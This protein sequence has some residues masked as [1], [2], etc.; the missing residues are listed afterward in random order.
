L[1]CIHGL[2]F[3]LWFFF[4]C[5]QFQL[6][7]TC[8]FHIFFSNGFCCLHLKHPHFR[9]LFFSF[10]FYNV[11]FKLSLVEILSFATIPSAIMCD[12]MLLM[13]TSGCLCDYFSNLDGFW[14]SFQLVVT[15]PISSF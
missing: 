4:Q 12:E 2:L 7:F 11:L 13:A 6:K 9:L 1:L 14:S 3:L 15:M 5:G 8:S 10:D